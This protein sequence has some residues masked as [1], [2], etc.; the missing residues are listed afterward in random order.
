MDENTTQGQRKASERI[1]IEG[2]GRW[3]KG[4]EDARGGRGEKERGDKLSEGEEEGKENSN[5][6]IVEPPKTTQL[7]KRRS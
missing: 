3:Q 1:E 7:S 5:E 4:E 2:P 6:I